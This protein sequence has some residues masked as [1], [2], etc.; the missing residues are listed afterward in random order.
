[1]VPL[2]IV[3]ACSLV[4]ALSAL[5]QEPSP[6]STQPQAPAPSVTL[7]PRSHDEREARYQTQHH[8]I[9]NVFV[10]DESGKPVTGLKQDD[11]TL[12]DNGQPRKLAS[13]RSA[14]GSEGIAPVRVVL[15][16]DAVNNS[17]RG[18]AQD[19]MGVEQYFKQS[20]SPL[21]YPT[22]IALFSGSGATVGQPSKDRDALISEMSALTKNVH[23]FNCTDTEGG[24][25]QVF[26]TPNL[27]TGATIHDNTPQGEKPGCLNQR[28]KRSVAELIKFAIGQEDTLGRVL[29]IWIG[30]GWPLLMERE[31]STDSGAIQQNHF[32]NLVLISNTLREAQVT[33]DAVFSPDLGRKVEL[34]S[35]HDN[36][37][38]DGVPGEDQVRTS[39][40]G[41]QVLAHQSGGQILTES[42]DLASEIS[43]CV[44]HAESYYVLSFDTPAAS[45]PAEFHSLRV[46]ANQP[47]LRVRTS[48]VYYAQP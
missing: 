11:F 20:Q 16:L 39:S 47:G 45:K 35:D 43:K 29:L 3:G 42:K 28:F 24:S 22:S 17:P 26:A 13:F 1:M 44:A 41:L 33:L 38:F 32:D 40:L 15:M 2:K 4:L 18:I 31:F 9:L 5:G 8:V 12:I 21:A 25:Q 10:T 19:V 23:P 48:T 37:F 7:I 27:G 34:R 36:A 46:I 6:Q 30:R 14:R